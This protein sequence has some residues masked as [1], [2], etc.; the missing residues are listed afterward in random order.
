M[1]PLCLSSLTAFQSKKTSELTNPPL[2]FFTST[3]IVG[4]KSSSWLHRR[5]ISLSKAHNYNA[6]MY[7]R[8]KLAG[9]GYICAKFRQARRLARP[10]GE[11]GEPDEWINGLQCPPDF[12]PTHHLA[13][14]G[15]HSR[16]CRC[17]PNVRKRP[18]G[19]QEA[20][21]QRQ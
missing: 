11:W 5:P 2:S 13:I 1:R 15:Y 3:T 10:W 6:D 4:L 20:E 7:H 12:T 8:P 18:A 16:R 14:V 9:H 21:Q 19:N 17:C